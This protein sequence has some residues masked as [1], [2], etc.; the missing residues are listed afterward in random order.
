LVKQ[1]IASTTS[2]GMPSDNN[3][4]A[5]ISESSMTSLGLTQAL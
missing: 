4:S 1:I 2:V 5:V 3:S